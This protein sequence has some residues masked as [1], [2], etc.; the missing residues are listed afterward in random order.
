[1]LGPCPKDTILCHPSHLLHQRLRRDPS[2]AFS[3]SLLY[4]NSPRGSIVSSRL[5]T[6]GSGCRQVSASSSLSFCFSCLLAVW[7]LDSY[8][9]TL[10]LLRFGEA[11]R[12]FFQF[13]H[14]RIQTHSKSCHLWRSL[15]VFTK[16][17]IHAWLVCFRHHIDTFVRAYTY[18]HRCVI[19]LFGKTK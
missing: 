17:Y 1:M 19:L 9:L 13:S 16:S 14:L 10:S 8:V 6:C 2:T 15:Q 11:E 3:G 7:P 4:T 5:A 12:G 18:V